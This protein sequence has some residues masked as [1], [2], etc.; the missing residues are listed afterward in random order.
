MLRESEWYWAF[1]GGIPY[2]KGTGTGADGSVHT[3]VVLY[4]QKWSMAFVIGCMY[5]LQV[6]QVYFYSQH[7]LQ[8]DIRNIIN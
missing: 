8:C 4:I 2:N 5:K 6:L 1:L 7:I 3:I